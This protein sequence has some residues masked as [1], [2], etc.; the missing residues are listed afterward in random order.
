MLFKRSLDHLVSEYYVNLTD[1]TPT[2][3][4]MIFK[5]MKSDDEVDRNLGI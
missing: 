2:T 4:R 3:H 1:A 5:K